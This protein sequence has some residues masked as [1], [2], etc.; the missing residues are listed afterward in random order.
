MILHNFKIWIQDKVCKPFWEKMCKTGSILLNLLTSVFSALLVNYI[1]YFANS[2]QG[3][4]FLNIM[5]IIS[6]ISII[7]YI[8]G[9]NIKLLQSERLLEKIEDDNDIPPEKWIFGNSFSDE[10]SN[11]IIALFICVLSLL[12]SAF[13][14]PLIYNFYS[15]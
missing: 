8:I 6:S 11:R 12:L 13:I 14:V 10:V 9:L 15:L 1:F 3:M 7:Y 4:A 2:E 5:V